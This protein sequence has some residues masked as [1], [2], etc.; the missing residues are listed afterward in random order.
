[1]DSTVAL[2]EADVKDW[3]I[4]YLADLKN[5]DKAKIRTDV[6]LER[7]GLD[8]ATAVAMSGDLMDWCG[9]E[10]DPSAIYDYKTIHELAAYLVRGHAT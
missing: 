8:S 3:L 1:M 7:Y 6:S 5:I 2:T 4:T 10:L 9:K